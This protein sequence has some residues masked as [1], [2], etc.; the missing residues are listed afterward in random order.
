[1]EC[2]N[3]DS[4]DLIFFNNGCLY[5]TAQHSR[6]LKLQRYCVSIKILPLI[7][8]AVFVA[9]KT[10][11]PGIRRSNIGEHITARNQRLVHIHINIKLLT[12]AQLFF[13]PFII[14]SL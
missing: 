8:N 11:N 6:L 10:Y 4:I 14:T 1:M 7:S 2:I 5:I 3:N 13:T 9:S 12:S